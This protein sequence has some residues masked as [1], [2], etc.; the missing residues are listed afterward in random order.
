MKCMKNKEDGMV[1]KKINLFYVFIYITKISPLKFFVQY[2]F[3]TFDAIFLGL[4]TVQMQKVFDNA[5]KYFNNNGEYKTTLINL[6][7]LMLFS[8]LSEISSGTSEYFGEYYHDITLKTLLKNLNLKISKISPN[9]FN[10][11]KN[12]DVINS[13][14]IGAK[15]IRSL[16]N[17]IMD[18][19]FLYL[20]YY[21]FIEFYLIS[22]NPLLGISILLIFMPT[23]ISQ[24]IKK[25]YYEKLEEQHAPLRRKKEAYSSYIKN[26]DYLKETRTLGATDYI[27]NLF[28]ETANN[29]HN[30]R[31]IYQRKI[32]KIEAISKLIN[33]IGYMGVLGLSIYL[34]VNGKITVGAFAA[35]YASLSNL[36]GLME[37]IFEYRLDDIV[38]IYGKVKKYIDFLNFDEKITGEKS[39][40]DEIKNIELKNVS[41]IYPSGKMA[42]E[43]INL[44]MKKGDRIAII[45]KNG[46]GKTT[47]SKLILGLYRPENGEVY[48][49][50]IASSLLSLETIRKKGTAVFQN[51]NKYKISLRE[52]ISISNMKAEK[53]DKKIKNVL[54]YIGLNYNDKKF[55]NG[56]NTILS[57]E[58]EGT[59]LS[60]GQWQKVAIGRGIFKDYNIIILDEPTSALDPLAEN[61]LYEKFEEISR[62]KI[63]IIITHRLAS[64][65]FCNKIVIMDNGK[66]IDTGTHEELLNRSE[67]YKKLWYAQTELYVKEEDKF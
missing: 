57:K 18:L 26:K 36:F 39:I 1:N 66:I 41:F 44:K 51:F 8:I 50:G 2:L 20:P 32:N 30:L 11:P 55:T 33:I 53:N 47:L 43:N 7:Y 37:E 61:E 5:I 16:L 52:N 65:K 19:L 17:V 28:K 45:G 10:E 63:A 67:Y 34:I 62:E 13:A 6:I 46:A 25:K 23:I 9:F 3:A 24:I 35:V 40:I 27:F 56:I 60:G 22:L 58:F 29:Y 54:N 12:R 59:E 38:E 14:I 42:I 21:I 15:S 48:Y 4:I 64:I 31:L 49:N